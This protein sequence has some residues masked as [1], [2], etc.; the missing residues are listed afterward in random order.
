MILIIWLGVL[1]VM[2]LYFVYLKVIFNVFNEC[3]GGF[4]KKG[5]ECLCF[6]LSYCLYNDRCV[7]L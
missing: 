2:L 1:F 7:M 5:K 3:L 6:L 4:F